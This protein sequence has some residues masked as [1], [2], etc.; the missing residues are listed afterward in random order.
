[1]I[2]NHKCINALFYG[3]EM[4]SVQIGCEVNKHYFSTEF[5]YKMT[6][7]LSVGIGEKKEKK[8]G[9]TNPL[10]AGRED[11]ELTTPG[12]C[13][14]EATRRFSGTDSCCLLPNTLVCKDCCNFLLLCFSL[15]REIG[16]II[17]SGAGMQYFALPGVHLTQC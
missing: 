13:R 3:I 6:G 11:T 10:P 1:M 17:P 14:A 9:E 15:D 8:N 7:N 2:L 16:A 4:C 12:S 5:S